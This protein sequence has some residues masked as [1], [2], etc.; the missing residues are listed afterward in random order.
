VAFAF[1]ASSAAAQASQQPDP[2]RVIDDFELARAAG[3]V[4]AALAQF[5]DSAVV[6]IQEPTNTSYAGKSGVRDFLQKVGILFHASK[7]SAYVV[8]NGSV[9]WTER[10]QFAGMT[11]DA[12]VY[13]V[14]SGGLITSLTYRQGAPS[15]GPGEP[16]AADEQSRSL[17]PSF[18]W[19]AGLLL[20][21]VVMLSL[22]FRRPSRAA[23]ASQLD[24]RLLM[25]LR[26]Q[27][28][29]HRDDFDKAA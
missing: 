21:G 8:Q 28:A 4:D 29:M 18:A 23:G 10:E 22:V 25:E 7:R 20:L 24:G 13:A 12:D 26:R 2:R 16:A 14:V 1:A 27:R 6:T 19:P 15:F 17:L 3:A 5:A 9:T 11:F